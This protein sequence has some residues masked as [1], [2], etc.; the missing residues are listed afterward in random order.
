[1]A[2]DT[3]GKGVLESTVPVMGWGEE[4]GDARGQDWSRQLFQ[5]RGTALCVTCRHKNMANAKG[6]KS[7]HK[8]RTNPGFAQRVHPIAQ[9]QGIDAAGTKLPPFSR[10]FQLLD[11]GAQGTEEL[12]V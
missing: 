7:N 8:D 5:G 12:C 9:E 2:A 6:S 11:R 10:L 1:M 4:E 3:G